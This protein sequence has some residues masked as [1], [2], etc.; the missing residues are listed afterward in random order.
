[1]LKKFLH[2][3]A[4]GAG[5]GIAFVAIV[6]VL[7]IF[8]VSVMVEKKFE[9]SISIA[10]PPDISRPNKFLGSTNMYSGDFWN[11]KEGVLTGGPGEIVGEA[12]ASG[13]PAVKLKLRLALNG[14][15]MSQWATTDS[16][17]KYTIKVP[18]GEYRIDGFELDRSSANSVL[19]NKID[20]PQNAHSSSK[21]R[22]S[23]DAAGQGLGFRFIDPIVKNIPKNRFSLSEDIVIGWL[24]YPGASQ[25]TVQVLEK[26]DPSEFG[27][28]AL[29]E[30]S[31]RPTVSDTSINLK[32]H[33]VALKAGH[34][35]VLELD[36]LDDS[37]GIISK[38]AFTFQGFDFEVVE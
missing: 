22:V 34:Y 26:S 2:G 3:L 12:T 17:G 27:N 1:M 30:W 14:S 13:E 25:Y 36:A 31:D 11:K 8:F 10:V 6:V 4:F 28:E 37:K 35:Y 19:V 29:F 18:Y 5:F 7:W 21:F 33:N 20:H 32:E 38:T 24:A 15:V 23:E 9:R 16:N